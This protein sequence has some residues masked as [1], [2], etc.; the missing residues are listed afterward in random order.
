MIP[1]LEQPKWKQTDEVCHKEEMNHHRNWFSVHGSIDAETI[2]MLS[3]L[4]K[5]KRLICYQE[6]MDRPKKRF[7][8][9]SSPTLGAHASE[10]FQF[11]RKNNLGPM[12]SIPLTL[13]LL[14]QSVEMDLKM[15]SGTAL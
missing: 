12:K 13:H 8:Y 1:L 11:S 15:A 2:P 14:G 10:L 7:S 6:K 9:N 4:S 5:Q 3:L